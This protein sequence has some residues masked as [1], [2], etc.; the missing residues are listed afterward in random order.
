[1]VREGLNVIALYQGLIKIFYGNSMVPYCY[2]VACR[3]L[4]FSFISAG[5]RTGLFRQKR[6]KN[7]GSR[8]THHSVRYNCM[9]FRI[10][11]AS[12]SHPLCGSF[13]WM[14]PR[15]SFRHLA[16]N[17]QSDHFCGL[18]GLSHP[19]AVPSLGYPPDIHPCGNRSDIPSFD[20]C[21]NVVWNCS[22]S[23][24][25]PLK[26]WLKLETSLVLRCVS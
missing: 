19:L 14:S 4:A 21:K 20:G 26:R 25:N 10:L 18:P 5:S 6:T 11:S 8:K 13:T 2:L 16:K 15:H 1:M 24:V 12:A 17:V 3:C 22:N 23:C 7:L 9:W